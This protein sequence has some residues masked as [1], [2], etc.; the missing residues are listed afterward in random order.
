MA[1]RLFAFKRGLAQLL[2]VLAAI[3]VPGVPAFAQDRTAVIGTVTDPSGAVMPGVKVELKS[4]STG[5]SRETLTGA[6]G[7][8]EFPTLPIGSY[9]MTMTKTGFKPYEIDNIDLV[10]GQAR[11]VDATLQVGAAAEAVEV[12]ATS[13]I[14]NRT[15]AE[16]GQVVESEQINEIP[17]SGRN[18]ASL[19]LLAPGAVNYGDGAQ[20]AI[21]FNGHS[22][23]D[24]NF[25]FDGVDT[26]GVQEQT[27]KADTRLNIALG[28]IA[29]FRV[30]D[31]VYTAESGDAGGA[32]VN[33]VS[34]SGTNEFHGSAFYA[35]RNDALDA[36]SPFDGPTLPPFT[37]TSR[38]P[39]S[40]VR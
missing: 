4:L 31:A 21:Q 7:I 30:S 38:A 5:L 20:R 33:V 22:L 36:R 11:T 23:D 14:L 19:M 29:E 25:T 26:S 15:S 18:W 34:K 35:V 37:L 28:A 40:V 32:Q 2:V 3:C 13:E 17:I 39:T 8:Y 10:Y 12:N 6:T 1:T 9:N 27:Q 24:S 16:V